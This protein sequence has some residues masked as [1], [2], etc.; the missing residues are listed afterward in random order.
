[1]NISEMRTLVRQDLHDEDSSNYRWSDAVLDRH[2]QR[3]LREV[4]LASPQE[5]KA[6]LTTTA[7]SREL[8][9]ASLGDL[10][11]VEAVEYPTGQ[12]PAAYVRFS[13]WATTL[14]MLAQGV[15]SGGESVAVYYGKLHVLDATTSTIPSALEDLVATGAA[16]YAA[17]EWANFAVNRVNVGGEET[18][19]NYQ[20]WGQEMLGHF[21]AMLAQHSRRN[22]VRVRSL[23][24]PAEPPANQ[25]SVWGP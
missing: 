20:A 2:I 9:I 1:M 15:P 16:G 5:A 14:T 12:Y 19:R 10:V 13:L 7:G 21:Y 18:W 23:Y 22:A 11:H 17:L 6:T 4:S 24:F 25:S 8:S 3:A